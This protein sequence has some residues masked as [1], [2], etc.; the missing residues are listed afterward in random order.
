M[1]MLNLERERD[2]RRDGERFGGGE[3][4]LHDELAD[5][6]ER[7]DKDKDAK[8]HVPDEAFPRLHLLQPG[9]QAGKQASK[10]RQA[11]RQAGRQ[12]SKELSSHKQAN[13]TE[14]KARRQKGCL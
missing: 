14:E 1:P 9:N 5:F 10:Q 13:A 6:L 11:G 7:V 4:H 8:K 2:W 12:A 3:L